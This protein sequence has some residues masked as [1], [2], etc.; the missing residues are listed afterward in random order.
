M[1]VLRHLGL[2]IPVYTL[3]LNSGDHFAAGVFLGRGQVSPTSAILALVVET[4]DQ[5]QRYSFDVSKEAGNG[6]QARSIA[7]PL[8]LRS[9]SSARDPERGSKTFQQAVSG[10]TARLHS[11]SQ[12]N[13][14]DPFHGP[15]NQQAKHFKDE[16]CPVSLQPVLFPYLKWRPVRQGR[17]WAR[18]AGVSEIEP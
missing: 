10:A 15:Q 16:K 9:W 5:T 17:T 4:Q 14:G 1:F 6:F 12:A 11:S 8:K 3:F 18:G 7:G 2:V 13:S